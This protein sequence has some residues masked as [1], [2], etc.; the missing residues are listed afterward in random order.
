MGPRAGWA[1]SFAVILLLAGCVSTGAPTEGT[2]QAS[3]TTTPLFHAKPDS[4]DNFSRSN[5]TARPLAWKTVPLSWNGTLAGSA[6][7]CDATTNTCE[8]ATLSGDSSGLRV[9]DLVGI[10]RATH[11]ELRWTA[12]TPATATLGI[13]AMVMSPR[14]S[15]CASKMIGV[16][17]GASPLVIDAPALNIT[18]C[19]DAVLH[20]FLYPPG[21][22][23]GPEQLFANPPQDFS[24]AGAA[25]LELPSA[26]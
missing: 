19:P 23:A 17:E 21:T 13:G 24:V 26:R 8:G 15:S 10:V 5:S 18:L 4:I 2:T 12:A 16:V 20:V 3:R 6:Y 11:L 22:T 25:T 7:L 1:A 9:P 14:G